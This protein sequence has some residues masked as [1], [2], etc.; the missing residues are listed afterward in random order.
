[1]ARYQVLEPSFIDGL[2]IDK[3]MIDAAGPDGYIVNIPAFTGPTP[4]LRLLDD[5]KAAEA[6]AKTAL[7]AEAQKLGIEVDARSSVETITKAL[8]DFKAAKTV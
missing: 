7:L 5:K 3:N 2:L 6:E 8:A 1:M 4:N